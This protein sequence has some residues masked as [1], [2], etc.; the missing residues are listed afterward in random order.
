[1]RTD[2]LRTSLSDVTSKQRTCGVSSCRPI[3]LERH[4][5]TCHEK[6]KVVY[7]NR[8]DRADDKRGLSQ[9]TVPG[10]RKDNE[11]GSKTTRWDEE[12]IPTGRTV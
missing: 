11:T 5:A 7:P 3:I 2:R 1:M 10:Q 4:S 8:E 6:G 9:N 12:H